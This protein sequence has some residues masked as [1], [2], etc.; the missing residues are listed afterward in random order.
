[1]DEDKLMEL[2]RLI[3]FVVVFL[4]DYYHSHTTLAAA[5]KCTQ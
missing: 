3:V 4:Q 1:M 5:S 2:V